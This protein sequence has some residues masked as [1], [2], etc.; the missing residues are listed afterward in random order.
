MEKELIAKKHLSNC[1]FVKVILMLLVVF[2]HSI[3]FSAPAVNA[4]DV[5]KSMY[6]LSLVYLW[7]KFFHVYAFALASGYIF[8][9]KMNGGGYKDIGAFVKN[10][11]V[12]L[13]VPYVA[14]MFLWI[15]PMTHPIFP[16]TKSTF[17]KNYLLE[18]MVQAVHH[19]APK[20][21]SKKEFLQR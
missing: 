9:F 12:R 14:V 11:A 3:A 18:G 21:L 4:E 16:L 5:S 8:A 17:V 19:N 7:V 15:I 20:K 2:G 13:L 1:E 6:S 10:K